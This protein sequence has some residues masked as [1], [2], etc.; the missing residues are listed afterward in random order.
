M[1][2]ARARKE[3][4][5]D[6]TVQGIGLAMGSPPIDEN[7]T[8]ILGVAAEKFANNAMALPSA[9]GEGLAIGAAGVEAAGGEI[10]EIFGAGEKPL[11]QRF[12]ERLEANRQMFPA[13]A[14]KD[15][16][17]PTVDDVK[18]AGKAFQTA[19]PVPEF[20]KEQM[21]PITGP[22]PD[23][24][25]EFG[26]QK[27]L[28]TARSQL[29]QVASPVQDFAGE[30]LGDAATVLT[31]RAPIAKASRGKGLTPTFRFATTPGARKQIQDVLNSKGVQGA[32]KVTGRSAE[33]GLEGLALSILDGNDPIEM[34]AFAAGTQ[35]AGTLSLA[36]ANFANPLTQKG[37]SNLLMTA[38][39][40][41][42]ILTVAENAVP[43]DQGSFLSNV[44][45][46]FD[47]IS[48]GLIAGTLAGVAGAG[49]LNSTKLGENL[50][51]I[52][53][54][55][56]SLPRASLQSA[57]QDIMS[58]SQTGSTQSRAVFETMLRNPTV[59]DDAEI[60]RL[61]RAFEKKRFGAE[62]E[63]LMQRKDFRDKLSAR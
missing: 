52:A 41:G 10:G 9:L 63:K 31:G 39:G 6:Q 5:L 56:T 51:I 47:K 24:G 7:S 55:I 28:Q 58:E 43:G 44:E 19:A 20:F 57:I 36:A 27:F 30:A 50:P 29:E 13:S 61:N 33:A 16:P 12:D 1:L 62:V 37:R 17:A 26:R 8:S 45:T 3:D 11:G 40:I 49:R 35:A 53:D 18:A 23:F 22:Q 21:E 59:F 14:L 48:M 42:A 4:K 60:R 25:Q 34:G 32:L 38:A 54:G 46:G 15:I 2:R